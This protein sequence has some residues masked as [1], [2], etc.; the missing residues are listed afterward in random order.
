MFASQFIL[1]VRLL[2]LLL[3]RPRAFI[4]AVTSDAATRP[5]P[6]RIAY[7]CSKAASH[8]LF[9]GLSAELGESS[10]SV[11]QMLPERQVI[12]RGIRR[13]RPPDFDFSGYSSPEIFKEP[14]RS[15]VRNRGQGMNG[16]CLVVS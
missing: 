4:V 16:T 3:K 1:T 14:F 13:R 5:A 9:S 15:I 11:I 2:P 10:V 7:G 8:A 12:T 6:E